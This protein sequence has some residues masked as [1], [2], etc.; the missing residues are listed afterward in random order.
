[1]IHDF[2]TE[3]RMPVVLP[4]HSWEGNLIPN[5]LAIIGFQNDDTRTD[6]FLEMDLKT[7]AHILQALFFFE[8]SSNRLFQVP[9]E[10]SDHVRRA[11]IFF[12]GLLVIV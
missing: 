1:M 7:D 6:F 3:L 8:G 11:S 12:D 4:V 5:S 2:L 9:F 10:I